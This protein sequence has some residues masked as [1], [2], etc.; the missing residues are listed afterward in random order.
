MEFV[1]IDT[2]ESNSTYYGIYIV[3]TWQW[4]LIQIYPAS[5]NFLNWTW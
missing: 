5:E 4:H 3:L 2:L 1:V